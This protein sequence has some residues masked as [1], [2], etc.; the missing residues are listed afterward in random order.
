MMKVK[1]NNVCQT[2]KNSNL[3]KINFDRIKIEK[4]NFK[5]IE[6]ENKTTRNKKNKIIKQKIPSINFNNNYLHF[7]KI[8]LVKRELS[9]CNS[10]RKLIVHRTP[11]FWNK[12]NFFSNFNTQENENKNKFFQTLNN[13]SNNLKTENNKND[14]KRNKFF[15]YHY[16]HNKNNNLSSNNISEFNNLKKNKNSI[17]KR[18]NKNNKSL[19]SGISQI[20]LTTNNN[21]LTERENNN[22]KKDFIHIIKKREF[23]ER[24]KNIICPIKMNKFNNNFNKKI[25][26]SSSFKDYLTDSSTMTNMLNKSAKKNNFNND[27]NNNNNKQKILKMDINNNNEKNSNNNNNN[28]L[29]INK[30][31]INN[32]YL[33]NKKKLNINEKNKSKINNTIEVK[34]KPKKKKLSLNI[35]VNKKNP[36]SSKKNSISNTNLPTNTNTKEKNSD[37][38]FSYETD[39]KPP[40]LTQEEKNLYG[41]RT[42]SENY[43]KIKLLGKGGCG[44]VWLVKNIENQKEFACKQIS[45]KNIVNYKLAKSEIE[46]MIFIKNNINIKTFPIF[47]EFFEDNFDLWIIYEKC[48]KDLST[49]SIKIKGEFINK[50]RIYTIK[51]G[52]FLEHFVMKDFTQLKIFLKQ[53]FIFIQNL[54][55]F[56]IIH[57]DI[58]PENILIEHDENFN[59]KS[60]KIIDYGSSYFLNKNVNFSS[61]TP[62]YLSPELTEILEKNGNFLLNKENIKFIHSLKNFPSCIDVWSLG[63][64][65]LE[66]ITCIPL[67]MSY[68][69]KVLIKGKNLIKY[70]IF[71]VNGRD[72]NKIL[73][74][75]KDLGKK[76]NKIIDDESIC[77]NNLNDFE[78]FKDLLLKMLEFD[79]KK[80]IKPEDALNHPFLQC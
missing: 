69:T 45:K 24:E 39:L 54:N 38:F 27:F 67:W 33:K 5:I 52:K 35:S 32:D 78:L 4:N 71:G 72:A 23:S 70:G 47:Y 43:K 14:N 37:D 59:I 20:N 34:T 65:I 13:F 15:Y 3:K 12:N 66:I 75:Q 1:K 10:K 16:Y 64:T 58:K 74:I 60:I 36:S 22:I 30:K 6:N 42:P 28:N 21:I 55:K 53:M 80:R 77:N 76:L 68:K 9:E 48:G 63:A 8:K 7:E 49:L 44:I 57:G 18:K 19:Q 11:I 56:F 40:F 79:Y 25:N 46:M 50:E 26:N 31:N 51:K 62:E 17:I 2:P 29:K 73:N 41:D 61:N